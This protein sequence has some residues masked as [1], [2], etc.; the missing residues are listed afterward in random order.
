MIIRKYLD[1][2]NN[3]H[4]KQSEMETLDLTELENLISKNAVNRSK[5]YFTLESLFQKTAKDEITIIPEIINLISKHIGLL[6]LNEEETGNV[7]FSNNADLRPEFRQSFR[8]VDLLDF[9]FAILYSSIYDESVKNEMQKIPIPC[10]ADLF[11]KIVQ[12][13]N[14]FRKEKKI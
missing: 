13:G 5:D 11:W 9:S 10:D 2:I 3:W 7:C 6:F 1:Q 12:I 14:D 8:I 4:R